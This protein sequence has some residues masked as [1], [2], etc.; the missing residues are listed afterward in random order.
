MNCYGGPIEAPNIDRIAAAGARFTQWHTTALCSP[1]R[2]SNLAMLDD[3][4]STKTCNHY[5]TGWAMAVNTPFKMWKRYEFNGGT[6][7][8]CLIAWPAVLGHGGEIRHQHHHA[9]D[10]VPPILDCL[11]APLP[12]HRRDGQAG[13]GRRQRH[14]L[15]RP[16]APGRAAMLARE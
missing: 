2:K 4:G 12:V 13:R 8:P 9:I 11:G 1:T 5:P 6:A 10:I 7:G 14:A 15:R 3:L 16:G